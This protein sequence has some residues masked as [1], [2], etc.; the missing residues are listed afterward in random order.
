MTARVASLTYV[1][2]TIDPRRRISENSPR[3]KGK[4]G[5]FSATL[6]HSRLV[7]K[8]TRS[9]RT[10]RGARGA[11]EPRLRAWEVY[12]DLARLLPIRFL[13]AEAT[14]LDEKGRRSKFVSEGGYMELS[15]SATALAY[16]PPPPDWFVA[17]PLV[18]DLMSRWSPVK[19]GWPLLGEAN[20]C[21]TRLEGEF[22]DRRAAAAALNVSFKVFS[23]LGEL[24]SLNDP[25]HGRKARASARKLTDQEVAWVHAAVPALIAR[26]G[27]E[28]AGTLSLPVLTMS[29]LPA[30]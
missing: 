1:L 7:V 14:L 2:R 27:A 8:P 24:G 4:I 9:Y 10:V 23:K 28:A 18:A 11:I 6:H 20:W 17:G 22:G 26:A 30:L 12:A 16:P 5:N 21:L 29:D 13:F 15:E 19:D 25:E 3:W